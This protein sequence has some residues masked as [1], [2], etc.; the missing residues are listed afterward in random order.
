MNPEQAEYLGR[1]TQ[2]Q[3]NLTNAWRDYWYQY[4]NAGTWQF[5]FI[6]GMLVLPLVVL[7][8]TLDRD[9]ALQI[10][11][12]GFNVHMWFTYI[13]AI[14]IR[15]VRWEYPY[16]ITPIVPV[17]LALDASLIPVIYMLV[18]QWTRN[19]R[20]N[21][22]VYLTVVSL[23]LSFVFKPILT[24]LDLFELYKG[25]TYFHL[26]IGYMVTGLI[27]KWITNLFLHFQFGDIKS[28]RERFDANALFR[29]REKAK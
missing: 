9:K 23:L 16:R 22:Y 25:T 10:G 2:M 7:Y 20:K 29:R 3:D 27:S 19:H 4:S 14:G 1:L 8:F 28:D 26:F 6:L 18:Y 5:W 17:S 21:Y 15:L 24:A 11:F 12:Y 13:D